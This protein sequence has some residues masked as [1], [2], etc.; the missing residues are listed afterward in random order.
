MSKDTAISDAD[1]A[2]YWQCSPANVCL[3]RK[4]KGM[5]HFTS[6]R[7]ADEWRA[8]NAPARKPRQASV[9]TPA[10]S[11]KT[12]AEVAEKTRVVYATTTPEPANGKGDAEQLDLPSAAARPPDPAP[13]DGEPPPE[14][15]DVAQFIDHA[16]DFVELQIRNAKEVA[17]ITHGLLKL[18]MERGEPGAIAAAS[19]NWHEASK[20]AADVI[21]KFLAIQTQAGALAP[22]DAVADV[23]TTELEEIRKALRRLGRRVASAANPAAP[24]VAEMAINAGVDRILDLFATLDGRTQLELMNA[25]PDSEPSPSPS[26][27]PPAAAAPVPAAS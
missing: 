7:E 23:I 13:T 20:A 24:D 6:L 2:R 4:R 16:A 19:K 1:L 10:A 14:R 18:K 9:N 26:A 22:I 17:Q 5:P 25:E 27:Q 8:V 11:P 3:L 15:V 12:P 21:E